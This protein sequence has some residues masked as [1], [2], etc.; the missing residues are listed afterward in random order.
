[1]KP[2]VMLSMWRNDEQRWL[3]ERVR[4]L[5]SKSYPALRWLWLVGDSQDGTEAALRAEAALW[6]EADRV[7]I[8][9][10]DTGI[11]GEDPES[12]MRRLSETTNAFWPYLE[13]ADFYCLLHESDLFSPADVVER[14]LATQRCP[15]AGW[16]VLELANHEQVFY[17]TYAY[18]QGGVRF[19]NRAPYHACYR[20]DALFEVD[21]VGSVWLFH[22]GDVRGADGVRCADRAALDL[23]A[24]LKRR[25]RRIWVEPRLRIEQPLALWVAQTP[26]PEKE[27]AP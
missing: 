17:D 26:P 4:H 25:G 7:R 1:M 23:C 11:V 15:V 13:A 18:R 22:A 27:A 2:V 20:P 14:L 6:G 9:R 8:E 12:R 21:S 10:H 3:S 5:L 16:P 24:G 19:G